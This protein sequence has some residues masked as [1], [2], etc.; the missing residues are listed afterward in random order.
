L[1]SEHRAGYP[2]VIHL[3]SHLKR[4]R[5]SHLPFPRR[6]RSC[7]RRFVFRFHHRATFFAGTSRPNQEVPAQIRDARSGVLHDVTSEAVGGSRW[8]GVANGASATDQSCGE[9]EKAGGESR[10]AE[11]ARVQRAGQ[12]SHSGAAAIDALNSTE[13]PFGSGWELGEPISRKLWRVAI[14]RSA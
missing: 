2:T 10:L 8:R 6:F 12:A 7:G 1:G 11:G 13:T 14:I 3:G 5:I 4:R 9:A